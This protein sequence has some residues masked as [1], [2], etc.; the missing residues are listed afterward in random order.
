VPDPHE[1]KKPVN[2]V[3]KIVEITESLRE[4]DAGGES[5]IEPITPLDQ[6]RTPFEPKET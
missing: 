1:E 3:L 6:P 4:K 2:E 5:I